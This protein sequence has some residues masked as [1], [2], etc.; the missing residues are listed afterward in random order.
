MPQLGR[1]YRDSRPSMIYY[2]FLKARH[3]ELIHESITLHNHKLILR[4]TAITRLQ[5]K[6]GKKKNYLPKEFEPWFNATKWHYTT[7]D[8]C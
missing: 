4:E 5:I 8:I 1:Y 6:K 3:D 7:N 2:I